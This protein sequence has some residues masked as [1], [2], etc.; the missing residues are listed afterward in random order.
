MLDLIFWLAVS[1]CLAFSSLELQRF[2]TTSASA[3]SPPS[4][5]TYTVIAPLFEMLV[6]LQKS[7]KSEFW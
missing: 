3:G 1:A 4:Q 7:M 5:Q 6:W 2:M